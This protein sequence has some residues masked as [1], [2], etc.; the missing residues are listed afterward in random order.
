MTKTKKMMMGVVAMIVMVLPMALAPVANAQFKVDERQ[1]RNLGVS[2][3]NSSNLV[4]TIFAV[5]KGLLGVVF[6]VAVLMF[7]IAGLFF[8][9]SAGS[10]RAD[11]ARDMVTYAIIGL[12]VSVL[13]YAIVVFLSKALRGET[14]TGI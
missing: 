2:R 7:V 10:E 14:T 4:D 3:S 6:V 8:L 9:T 13:G 1:A 11:Q 5:I 12:V